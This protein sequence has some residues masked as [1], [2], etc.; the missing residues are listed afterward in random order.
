MLNVVNGGR[1]SA[2]SKPPAQGHMPKHVTTMKACRFL[3]ASSCPSAERTNWLP[4]ST[5][6]QVLCF[7]ENGFRDQ[8]RAA[9]PNARRDA[10]TRA[11]LVETTRYSQ[12]HAN[13]PN[14]HSAPPHSQQINPRHM[15]AK[16]PSTN[17]RCISHIPL[18]YLSHMLHA[19]L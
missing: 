17:K 4:L 3:C 12:A 14:S 1:G 11:R 7:R 10:A 5:R 13:Q 6:P 19:C 8:R 18:A 2:Q 16:F 15:L 9:S